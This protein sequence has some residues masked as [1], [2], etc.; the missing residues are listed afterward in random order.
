MGQF[1]NV[2][3]E[4]FVDSRPKDYVD[5]TMLIAEV[6]DTLRTDSKMS[7]VTRCRRFGKSMA[8]AMLC[9]YYDK[10]CDSRHIFSGFEIAKHPSF[11]THL[12]KYPVIYV[13]MTDL[14]SKYGHDPEIVNKMQFAIKKDVMK[15]YPQIGLDDDDDLMDLLLKISTTTGERFFMIIDEWDAICREFKEGETVTDQYIQFL[16]RLFKNTNTNRVFVGAYITGI[17]PIKKYNT[18]SA[19]NNFWEYTMTAPG[20]WEAYFGFTG[21]EVK[22]LCSHHEM[23]FDEM[24]KWYDG[25]RIGKEPSIFN[26]NSVMQALKKKECTNYWSTTGAFE[27]VT[28]YIQMNFQGLKD[29]IVQML[30]GGRCSVDYGRFGNDLKIIKSR[31]DVLTVLIHLG[32]LSYD[33][34]EKKCYIPNIEVGQELKKAVLETS[35]TEVIDALSASEALMQ[36]PR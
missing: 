19:L 15:A 17:L 31:D 20:G 23:D 25:Y 12:N 14:I 34:I 27:N 5:K 29:D 3:N 36:I 13:A 32:Y 35:W 33:P 18:E 6:N 9:A 30:A 7:C 1:I 24:R 11:E 22:S 28:T 21:D 26:P 16:R 8:A 2:G 10:S 4:V